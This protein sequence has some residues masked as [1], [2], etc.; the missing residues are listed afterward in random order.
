[1]LHFLAEQTSIGRAK[2][3]VTETAFLTET[4]FIFQ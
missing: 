3:H 2:L 1:M 4:R